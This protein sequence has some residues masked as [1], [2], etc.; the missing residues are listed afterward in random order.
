MVRR[1]AAI[2]RLVDGIDHPYCR[3][4]CI[5]AGDPRR[6]PVHDEEALSFRGV[7]EVSRWLRRNC[8]Q[9]RG[10][11]TVRQSTNGAH[12]P[13]VDQN[14]DEYPEIP[15]GPLAGSSEAD[16]GAPSEA[17]PSGAMSSGRSPRA[18]ASDIGYRYGLLFAW[19]I[20]VVAFA[21]TADGFLS[22][23]NIATILNSQVVL[24]VI[25]LALLVPLAAG[26]FDL[27]GHY[28]SPS[29]RRSAPASWSAS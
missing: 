28:R 23:S 13:R 6:C 10:G 4:S 29:P 27:A 24:L 14:T 15:V 7:E 12:E 17:Q 18:L 21:L 9:V 3:T 11:W 1:E 8:P 5:K 25:A 20:V 26:E 2:G 22:S 19:A 16:G